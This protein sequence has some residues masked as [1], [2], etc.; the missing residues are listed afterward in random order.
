MFLDIPNYSSFEFSTKFKLPGEEFE[1]LIIEIK[2]KEMI[3][4]IVLA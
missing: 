2:K 1:V 4:D 3:G